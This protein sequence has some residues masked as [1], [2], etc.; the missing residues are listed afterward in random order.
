MCITCFSCMCMRVLFFEARV[1]FVGAVNFF[2][3][4]PWIIRH[5]GLRSHRRALGAFLPFGVR[6]SSWC[7]LSVQLRL[8]WRSSDVAVSL[9]V[10][11]PIVPGDA[12][13]GTFI[14]RDVSMVRTKVNQPIF[15]GYLCVQDT[16]TLPVFMHG[17]L[18]QVRK[19]RDDRIVE[20][21]LQTTL[22]VTSTSESHH[23]LRVTHP[24]VSIHYLHVTIKK[25]W[26]PWP[27]LVN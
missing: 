22:V 4:A 12:G 8:E 6:L 9:T 17:A 7:W 25:T 18:T 14:V 11:T 27:C 16:M 20:T 3:R 24:F 15:T 23:Q 2:A 5:A 26:F 10:R 19:I 21:E 1:H 13:S